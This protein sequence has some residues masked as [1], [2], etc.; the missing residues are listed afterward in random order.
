MFTAQTHPVLAT[1][2]IKAIDDALESDQGARY[3]GLLKEAIAALDDA[4]DTSNKAFR[5]HLGAS[6]IGRECGRELWY[7]FHW[8]KNVV[9]SGRL[10][11]LFN[12]GHLE[13]GRFVALLRL[14]N[15]EVWQYT[16]EGN[17]YRVQGHD[18]HFGGS[19]DIVVRGVPDLP[20]DVAALGEFKTHGEK[21]FLKLVAEGVRSAKFEHWVQMQIY[22]GSYG[23][24]CA[25]YLAVNKN[26]DDLYGEIVAFDPEQYAQFVDRAHKV[27]YTAD[28]PK[29]ISHSPG[30]FKCKFCDYKGICH[31][32]EP[33]AVN[34]RTCVYSSPVSDGKWMCAKHA[35]ELPRAMQELGC[36]G[37]SARKG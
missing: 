25:L 10:L 22:M 33:L 11:R 18:G 32:G 8:S 27:I 30:W 19:L 36:Q 28:P 1:K 35:Q 21:S 7:G 15:C 37:Y 24:P 20:P 23:L 14:I 2:T 26:T 34:C 13:E 16:S 9:H 17:Q 3:R 12:R 6:L 31:H 5:K 29:R 4:Y